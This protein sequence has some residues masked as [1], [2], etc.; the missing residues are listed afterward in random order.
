MTRL[1]QAVLA[2]VMLLTVTAGCQ[3]TPH[4]RRPPAAPTDPASAARI[5]ALLDQVAGVD[6]RHPQ[7]GYQ[8]SCRRGDACTFGPAWTDNTSAPWGHDGCDTRDQILA[9]ALVDVRYRPGSDCVVIAGTLTD[10]YTGHTVAFAKAVGSAVAVDHLIPL[11]LAYDLGAW[12]WDPARRAAFAND[13][14]ELTAT[15]GPVNAAKG[16]QGLAGW[17]P[18]ALGYRCA[19]VTRF[20]TVAR[21]YGLPIT[22]GDRRAAQTVASHAC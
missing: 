5:T 21:L 2:G 6:R 18:P 16:D 7:P 20:L 4:A 14:R 10:P 15:A 19:Y 22:A 13:P 12:H 1:R 8:R 17:L 11:A 3:L 9:A